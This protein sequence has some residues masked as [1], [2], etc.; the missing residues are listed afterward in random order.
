MYSFFLKTY[1]HP[2]EKNSNEEK[3]FL[4]YLR[5]PV[6]G[7]TCKQQQATF[8]KTNPFGVLHY[9]VNRNLGHFTLRQQEKV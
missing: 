5:I 1:A 6:L 9:S 4:S 2:R 8:N 3:M 7:G